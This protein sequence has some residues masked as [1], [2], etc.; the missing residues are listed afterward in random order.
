[1]AASASTSGQTS[2]WSGKAKI[3]MPKIIQERVTVL[4]KFGFA[5]LESLFTQISNCQGFH[6]II[7]AKPSLFLPRQIA[8][9]L[10][11]WKDSENGDLA[12]ATIFLP[13]QDPKSF[14]CLNILDL[15]LQGFA[16][17]DSGVTIESVDVSLLKTL[18]LEMVMIRDF[19]GE[20]ENGKV[21]EKAFPKN[22]LKPKYRLLCN[23]GQKVFLSH[24]GT[25]NSIT[26]YKFSMMVAVVRN[27]DINWTRVLLKS[28]R[29]KTDL[30][31]DVEDK[32]GK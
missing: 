22:N 25:F 11:T 19:Y 12:K 29:D 16:L 24:S 21:K 15:I 5:E 27:L 9:F 18:Y 6:N 3:I 13:L 7:T 26:P 14:Q 17:E 32:A 1:M 28:L 8:A 10:Y 2:S 31:A 23:F 4:K 30:I 20:M